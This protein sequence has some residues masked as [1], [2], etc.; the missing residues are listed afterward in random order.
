[1]NTATN[2]PKKKFRID[3]II[4][5]LIAAIVIIGVIANMGESKDTVSTSSEQA[6]VILP[7]VG[8]VL[9]TDYFDVTVNRYAGGIFPEYRQ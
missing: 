8:Q 3:K 9:K 5:I 1:M 2:Q 7:T 4:L 6:K